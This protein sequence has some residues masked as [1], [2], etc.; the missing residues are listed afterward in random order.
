MLSQ[1]FEVTTKLFE[2]QLT[3]RFPSSN[4][5]LIIFQNN[6]LEILKEELFSTRE[7][8]NSAQNEPAPTDVLWCQTATVPGRGFEPLF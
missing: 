8:L 2:E 1:K 7:E 6:Q 4:R 5:V 3:Q